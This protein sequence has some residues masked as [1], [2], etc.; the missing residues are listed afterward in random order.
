MPGQH[1]RPTPTSLVNGVCAFRCN[2]PPALLAE[3]PGS[4]TCHCANTGV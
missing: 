3:W 4:F 2:L 1:S